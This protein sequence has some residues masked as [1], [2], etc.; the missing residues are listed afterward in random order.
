[1]AKDKNR[2]EILDTLETLGFTV[3]QLEEIK[4]D[5]YFLRKTRKRCDGIEKRIFDALISTVVTA[6]LAAIAAMYFN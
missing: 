2:Q 4:A 3:T 6:I 5:Q 1:M